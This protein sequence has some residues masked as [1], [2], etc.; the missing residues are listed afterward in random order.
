MSSWMAGLKCRPGRSSTSRTPPPALFRSGSCSP[1]RHAAHSSCD[2]RHAAGPLEFTPPTARDEIGAE[3][4]HPA[5]D[6]DK[7][8]TLHGMVRGMVDADAQAAQEVLVRQVTRDICRRQVTRT[9][10]PV[11]RRRSRWGTVRFV[12]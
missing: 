5:R 11:S 9:G 8:N 10:R 3:L 7:V 6:V 1:Q 12:V 4:I 2:V